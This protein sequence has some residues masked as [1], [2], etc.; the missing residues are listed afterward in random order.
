MDKYTF[1]MLDNDIVKKN[2]SYNEILDFIRKQRGNGQFVGISDN[3]IFSYL[4]SKMTIRR[5]NNINTG[6]NNTNT[7]TKE[8]WDMP[9]EE[10]LEKTLKTFTGGVTTDTNGQNVYTPK[11]IGEFFGK[12]NES[13]KYYNMNNTSYDPNNKEMKLLLCNATI[14]NDNGMVQ[15]NLNINKPDGQKNTANQFSLTFNPN[16][17]KSIHRLITIAPGSGGWDATQWQE[18]DFKDYKNADFDSFLMSSPTGEMDCAILKFGGGVNGN[19][20]YDFVPQALDMINNGFHDT[21]NIDNSEYRYTFTGISIGAT[22]TV[23]CAKAV[24]Q[25]RKETNSNNHTPMDFMLLDAANNGRD[26]AKALDDELKA[27]LASTGSVIYAYE[28]KATGP[29]DAV[30]SVWG[31]L[32]EDDLII[33]E[34]ENAGASN[35]GSGRSHEQ[36]L[37]NGEI[38]KV[39]DNF[40]NYED[41]KPTLVNAETENKYYLVIPKSEWDE[42]KGQSYYE[43]R[44]AITEKQLNAFS[45]YREIKGMQEE[46]RYLNDL[47]GYVES[48]N[49]EKSGYVN[50]A[51]GETVNDDNILFA[52]QEIVEKANNIVGEVNKT[53]FRNDGFDYQLCENSTSDFPESLNRGNAFLYGISNN[54]LN[55]VSSDS[56]NI[57][58]MLNDF[59]ALDNAYG[60]KAIQMMNDAYSSGN[61][62]QSDISIDRT[63]SGDIDNSYYGIFEENIKE[64]SAG[65]IAMSDIDSMLSGNM[66]TGK[67]ANALNSEYDDANRLKATIEDVINLPQGVAMGSAWVAEKAR[68][69]E[70]S[71]CCDIRMTSAKKLQEAYVDALKNIKD[72]YDETTNLL[73]GSNIN[74]GGVL[75]DGQ[76]PVCEAKV[77]EL[78]QEIDNL[79]IEY[80]ECLIVPETISVL[81]SGSGTEDD[82]YRYETKP[83]PE[84]QIARARI[85]EINVL[86]PQKNEEINYNMIYISQLQGLANALNKSNEIVQNA[87]L[88]INANYANAVKSIPIVN[89]SSISLGKL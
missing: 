39:I 19:E 80:D 57:G 76:I 15:V 27:E 61:Y 56:Q 7:I 83:N 68:L 82:P 35:H 58:I 38:K 70:L 34:V 37:S 43:Q 24:M 67:I 44:K 9:K 49:S 78:Q 21:E 63:I 2:L 31:P 62:F 23:D 16:N 42:N 71:D 33:V 64:G 6:I 88:E 60:K 59:I 66:L 22:K 25:Y 89:L 18:P 11:V 4:N 84:Y 32:S 86:I 85:A 53:N 5:T 72:Y 47:I 13:Y 52:F 41:N 87:I 51:S 54:L 74:M 1:N 30:N 17:N 50:L 12:N 73:V 55:I 69:I 46:G 36:Q 40:E 10:L 29:K 20:S 45:K 28:A 81:V 77:T 75:D 48:E 14:I 26:F 8:F 65:K 79:R 3:E